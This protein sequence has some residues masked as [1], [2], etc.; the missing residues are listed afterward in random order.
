MAYSMSRNGLLVRL[1]LHVLY[2]II[3]PLTSSFILAMLSTHLV[4]LDITILL[5][6]RESHLWTS[7]F[8]THLVSINGPHCSAI[9]KPQFASVLSFPKNHYLSVHRHQGYWTNTFLAISISLNGNVS[10]PFVVWFLINYQWLLRS[11]T[12]PYLS[13]QWDHRNVC[14]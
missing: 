7:I 5:I 8:F 14:L 11:I 10:R 6:R 4:L 9:S 13:E 3:Q 12:N 1:L 2:F